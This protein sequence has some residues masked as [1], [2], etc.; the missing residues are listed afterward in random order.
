MSDDYV[1]DQIFPSYELHLFGGASGSG[2]TTLAGQ[3]IEDWRHGKPVF[4]Y[5]SFPAPFCYIACDRSLRSI[6]ATLRRIGVPYEEWPLLSLVDHGI[7]ISTPLQIVKRARELCPAV[8]VIFLDGIHTLCPGGHINDYGPVQEF[9]TNCTRICQKE[10]VT[11]FGLG[12][13][14]KVKEGESFLHPRHRFLGSV[15][16]G[17]FSDTMI[18]IDQVKPQD[19]A[20]TTRT[21][22]VLPRNTEGMTLRYEIIDGKFVQITDVGNTLLDRWLLQFKSGDTVSTANIQTEGER[23]NISRS[24]IT[25]W[26]KNSVDLGKLLKTGHGLYSV[27]FAQ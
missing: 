25:R 4:G 2:K 5:K 27:S 21:V 1:V 7:T 6:Q 26:I 19:P 12:H 24:T 20:D 17:G 13:A 18:I 15:A 23:L 22:C 10:K 16:W 8:E 11:M 14:T 9:L 3:V